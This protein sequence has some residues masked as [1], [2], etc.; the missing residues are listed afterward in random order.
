MN[1]VNFVSSWNYMPKYLRGSL[2]QPATG[3]YS[4]PEES[5]PHQLTFQLSLIYFNIFSG[6]MPASY[7]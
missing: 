5:I 1:S 4:E 7:K 2:L 6:F 3:L